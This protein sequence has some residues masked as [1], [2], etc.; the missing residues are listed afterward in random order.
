MSIF[1]VTRLGK[2][3]KWRP[4]KEGCD[5]WESAYVSA[6]TTLSDRKASSHHT[7]SQV[8]QDELAYHLGCATFLLLSISGI[9][10]SKHGLFKDLSQTHHEHED[11]LHS[12][13]A[14]GVRAQIESAMRQNGAFGGVSSTVKSLED[15]QAESQAYEQ[16]QRQLKEQKRSGA[17]AA[18]AS[19][20]AH[21]TRRTGEESSPELA[22][23]R[24][25]SGSDD[26]P[27]AYIKKKAR[28]KSKAKATKGSM[29]NHYACPARGL[30]WDLSLFVKGE[31]TCVLRLCCFVS[32]FVRFLRLVFGCCGP[33]AVFLLLVRFPQRR[34]VVVW[35]V[36]H[37]T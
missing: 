25:G 21:K 19:P 2:F 10:R 37:F 7:C 9:L 6:G 22:A 34:L 32:R 8:I 26:D 23:P 11:S 15:A 27:L 16:K 14:A 20:P 28:A 13:H 30:R 4:E 18:P 35:E 33:F 31:K 17:G 12:G 24:E 5:G 1:G 29:G 36:M 3:V